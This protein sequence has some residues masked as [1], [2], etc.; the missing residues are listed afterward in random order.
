METFLVKLFSSGELTPHGFCLLWRPELLLLHVTSD[1][2]I[3]VSYY[4]IPLALAYF[5]WK[6]K[7]V[8]FGWVFWAFAAFILACGTTH[9]LEIWTIWHPDYGLQG[10]VKFATAIASMGTAIAVWLLMP[11]ALAL[12]SPAQYR[13]ISAAL[14]TEIDQHHQASRALEANEERYRR[15]LES[16]SDYAIFSL[17]ASGVILDWNKGGE[18]IKGYA[19]DEVIGRHF[20]IF[21]AA[22]DRD[23]GMPLHALQ[24]A[25]RNG[26]YEA[27][28]LR[29]RKDGSQFWANV[30]I[31][32]IRDNSGTLVGFA[33]ITRD[34]GYRRELEERLRQ[35]QKMEAIGQLIGG[36]A[37]DFNNHLM[38]ILAGLDRARTMAAES[39]HLRRAVELAIRGA[40]RASSLTAQLLAFARRQ[41]LEPKSLDIGRLLAETSSLLDRALGETIQIETIRAGGLWPAFCDAAQL[42]A[43]LLNL[44][45]N[46]RDA[47]PEG[48][49]LT[50]EV[51]NAYL[52]D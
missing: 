5:V 17:D 48:G 10:A 52:D 8:A 49:K 24:E 44:A 40:E 9:W 37:H 29:V 51:A 13:E 16:I 6:R 4:V 14:S 12:P 20:S 1:A 43:A 22:E 19:A 35:S 39:A 25:Q 15:L 34:I 45:V 3:A 47:M 33:K 32:P 26:R 30:V 42:E 38:V 23:R 41:P 2:A 11:R 50:L 18:S 28:A 36:I 7:D 21:Y 46:A 31:Q 27:E